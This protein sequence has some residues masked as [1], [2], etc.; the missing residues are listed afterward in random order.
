[1]NISTDDKSRAAR[2]YYDTHDASDE[3]AAADLTSHEPA[4]SSA[5]AGYSVRLPVE[6]LNQARVLAKEQGVSTGAWLREAIENAVA[7]RKTTTD[8]V[9]VS[10][11]LGLV[12][13]Y[14][15]AAEPAPARTVRTRQ[16]VARISR[17]GTSAT[18]ST[19]GAFRVAAPAKKKSKKK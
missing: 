11:L 14:A 1:M 10:A 7:A 16:L 12:Q 15:T 13:Q 8:T 17:T 9:P 18:R 19:T 3:I 6:V 5:L 2:D 4:E